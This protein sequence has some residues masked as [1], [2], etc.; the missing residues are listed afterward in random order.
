MKILEALLPMAIAGL[1]AWSYASP[2]K[3]R[4]RKA[5]RDAREARIVDRITGN[6]PMHRI[7]GK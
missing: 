7:L 1:W 5:Q 3:R 6:T 4:R 2:A